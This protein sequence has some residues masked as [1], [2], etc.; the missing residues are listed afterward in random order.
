V[1]EIATCETF[2][3]FVPVFVR[4]TFC[5][6][7]VPTAT[8]PKLTLVALGLKTPALSFGAADVYPMQLVSVTLAAMTK[9]MGK[10]AIRL[11]SQ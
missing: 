8:S 4:L 2:T 7:V 1:P 3:V 6:P 10:S 9:R 5:V 11:P